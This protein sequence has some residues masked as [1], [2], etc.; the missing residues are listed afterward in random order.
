MF[1]H[2]ILHLVIKI[3]HIKFSKKQHVAATNVFSNIITIFTNLNHFEFGFEDH[4]EYSPLSLINLSST[5]F[6][7]TSISYL[8]VTVQYFNDCLCLFD[9]RF[10]QLQ[11]VIVKVE[12]I[13]NSSQIINNK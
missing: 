11:T 8:N 4:F 1:K 12:I 10:T 6:Y 7:S 2:Q 9:G 3:N 13:E 5:I